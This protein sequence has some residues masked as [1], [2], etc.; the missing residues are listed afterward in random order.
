M[1]NNE[2]DE[3]KALIKSNISRGLSYPDARAR[4]FGEYLPPELASVFSSPH[5]ILG[6]EYIRAIRRIDATLQPIAIGRTGV[7]HDSAHTCGGFTSASNIRRLIVSGESEH[8]KS[9]IPEGIYEDMLS[10]LGRTAPI[11]LQSLS[12]ETVYALRRMSKEQLKSLPDVTEGLENLL[13]S[14]CRKYA[15]IGSVL[16]AVKSRRY[17]MARLKR[18][19][20]CAL[21]GIYGSPMKKLDSLFI[22]V[23]GIRREAQSL[24]SALHEK[25][26][27]PVFTRYGDVSKLNERQSELMALEVR[28]ADIAALGRPSPSPVKSDFSYPLIIV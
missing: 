18:I 14:A 5:D 11:M 23:L 8:I 15:D 2:P 24:L 28:C 19:C 21:L 9:Y 1:L 7:A 17:T 10:V 6:I 13:Y 20:M 4:A 3:L 12:R 22:R 27:L 26:E 25:S 16:T